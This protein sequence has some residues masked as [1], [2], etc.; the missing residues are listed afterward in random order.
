[1]SLIAVAVIGLIILIGLASGGTFYY[2]TRLQPISQLLKGEIRAN[3]I[4]AA[5]IIANNNLQATKA[6]FGTVYADDITSNNSLQAIRAKFRSANVDDLL[7]VGDLRATKFELSGRSVL[8]N[9][10]GQYTVDGSDDL[11]W[12]P[13]WAVAPMI[14]GD[15]DSDTLRIF[16]KNGSGTL[17]YRD[18]SGSASEILNK[19]T[20]KGRIKSAGMDLTVD[21][22]QGDHIQLSDSADIPMWSVSTS[23]KRSLLIGRFAA[24]GQLIDIPIQIDASTG[25]TQ[26][27]MLRLEGGAGKTALSIGGKG[28][29]SIDAPNVPGGRLLVDDA[30]N[31]T[32]GN[33]ITARNLVSKSN[34]GWNWISQQRGKGDDMAFGADDTN[35]GIWSYG[36]RPFGIYGNGSPNVLFGPN[37]SEFTK[38][39]VSRYIYTAVYAPQIADSNGAW[40]TA[41]NV[42]Y[43]FVGNSCM[44]SGAFDITSKSGDGN[45]LKPYM[46]LPAAVYT[47]HLT[48][49]GSII[50]GAAANQI[51]MP[52][53]I[54][55]SGYFAKDG[56]QVTNS[57]AFTNGQRIYVNLNYLRVL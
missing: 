5:D 29:F 20:V 22:A 56:I 44:I 7:Q 41:G 23:D 18:L 40:K 16:F 2:K 17:F 47:N 32:A 19:L 54:P 48:C 39:I 45:G 57:S 38:P 28:T 3:N 8:G 11:S 50:A 25:L 51:L 13:P 43:T 52:A 26:A 30:G 24:D 14:Y 15:S 42:Y 1:M 21:P 49:P 31:L 53:A 33:T 4:T 37:Y 12:L 6:K 36:T 34:G 55:N 27:N 10:G 35:R 9:L 46:T